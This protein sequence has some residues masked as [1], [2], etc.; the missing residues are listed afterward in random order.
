MNR[1][2]TR[3]NFAPSVTEQDLF[4]A[5]FILNWPSK[6]MPFNTKDKE[7]QKP[8]EGGDMSQ[9]LFC[10]WTK[11]DGKITIMSPRRVKIPRSIK[12][13]ILLHE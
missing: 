2:I 3:D 5:K 7:Y 13:Q 12:V 1:G 4:N 8:G 10:I 6:V 9:D 11:K